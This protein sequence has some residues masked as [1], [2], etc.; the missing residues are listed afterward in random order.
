M[1]PSLWSNTV[2]QFLSELEQGVYRKR[3]QEHFESGLRSGVSSTPTFFINGIRHDDYWDADTLL[4]A[5]ESRMKEDTGGH[6][7]IRAARNFAER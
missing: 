3:V 7:P 4:A 5:T 6:R 1:L 2:T